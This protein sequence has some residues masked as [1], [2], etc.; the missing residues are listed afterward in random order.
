MEHPF[1]GLEMF[2]FSESPEID[3]KGFP[4]NTVY[5]RAGSNLKVEIPVSGKPVPKVTL[6]RDG[7]A[8]KPT[9]RFHTETTAESLIINLKES[10]A[11]DAGRYDITAANSSGT[12]KSFVNIVVLDRPGPP[13]GPVVLSDVT[14]ES[15]TLKWQP[16]AYDGGSQ[17]TNYIVLKRE[18]S[19]AAWSEV[20]ATVART[21]IKVM[22][23]TTGEEYQFRIKAEN[24]FGIS[25]HIDSQCVVVKLPYSE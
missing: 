18:T 2:S 15:V 20:S 23:L 8:L 16:P 17:V 13:V 25:D 3:M 10:V 12:T 1:N 5:V 11:A 7:V 21:V 14:E 24:R 4:H 22:R 9:M 6:S 19:T